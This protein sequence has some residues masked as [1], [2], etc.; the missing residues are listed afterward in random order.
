MK[1]LILPGWLINEYGVQWLRD[2]LVDRG[3]DVDVFRC[4]G[5][6]TNQ[7]YIT[8]GAV[9]HRLR[10]TLRDNDYDVIIAHGY[11]VNM[12]LQCSQLFKD[13]KLVLL[14]PVYN[15]L[16]NK[17]KVLKPLVN[18]LPIAKNM[19][20][21]YITLR[22]A[23]S[24]CNN[25][26]TLASRNLCDGYLTCNG[27]VA[28]RLLHYFLKVKPEL[29]YKLY[30]DTLIVHGDRDPLV[31]YEYKQLN[32]MFECLNVI[33]IKCGHDTYNYIPVSVLRFIES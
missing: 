20:F 8:H 12:L 3:H 24:K 7:Y 13:A 28:R 16:S 31:R 23:Y 27:R 14:S 4:P 6:S 15:N 22:K 19:H 21:R 5:I 26:V 25:T 11:S 32:T 29:K 30:N 2:E 33:S 17:A 10:R 1:I 18:L 9:L